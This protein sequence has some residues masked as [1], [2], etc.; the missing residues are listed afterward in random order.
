[1]S[2][3]VYKNIL[4]LFIEQHQGPVNEETGTLCPPASL[5]KPFLFKKKSCLH[6]PP[7]QFLPETP[8]IIR[9][10]NRKSHISA[11]TASLS[12]RLRSLRG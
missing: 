7:A 11:G 8:A 6:F 2:S 1:M 5:Y 9:I 4:Q 10:R 12:Q 3:S